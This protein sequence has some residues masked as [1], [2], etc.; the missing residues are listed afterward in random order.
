M[1][2]KTGESIQ[3]ERSV[4]PAADN[5]ISR[6]QF[7]REQLQLLNR[8]L[9]SEL[10]VSILVSGLGC[11]LFWN[12][13]PV[14][15]LLFW[16]FGIVTSIALR[17]LAIQKSGITTTE[18]GNDSWD[19]NYSIAYLMTGMLWG[20]FGIIAY[21]YGSDTHN[22]I[23]LFLLSCVALTT[24]ASAGTSPLTATVFI[25]PAFLPSTIWM[26]SSNNHVYA[27]SATA[28][29]AVAIVMIRSSRGMRDVLSRSMKLSS[30]NAD[31]IRKLV[32]EHDRTKEA[33]SNVEKINA[34]MQQEIR[35]RRRAESRI[36]ASEKQLS[37]I[38]NGMQDTIYQT[39]MDG[40]ITW[41]TPSVQQLLGLNSSEIRNRN[42]REFYSDESSYDELMHLLSMNHGH[43]H[44]HEVRMENIAGKTMWV[45]EN[46]HYKYND[47]GEI[48]GVEGTIRN[49]TA[50]KLAENELFQEKERMEVT[51]GSIGDGVIT[52]DVEGNIIY[53]NRI[54][55]H[56]TG[57]S[58]GEAFDQPLKSVFNIVDE[59]TLKTP[60]D[61]VS[62]S[63]KEGKS[64][65]LPGYLLLIHRYLNQRL[66]VEVLASPIRDSSDEII[67]VVLVFHDVSELR[68]LAQM[69]YQA[70]HDLLTGLINRRE[71]ERRVG[72]ALENA[73]QRDMEYALCYL[74]LDNFKIV[75]DTCGHA[76]GDELLMQ[77]TTKLRLELRKSDTLARL[78]GD[79]FGLLLPG[80]SQRK[81]YE[82]AENFRQI[83]ENFRFNWDKKTFRVGVS[84][85]LVM[86][87]SES[88][89]VSNILSAAD[90]A[91]YVAK[92]EGRN[93]VHMYEENDVA[94]AERHGQ[95]QWVQRIHDVLE[96]GMFQLYFQ[97][98]AKLNRDADEPYTMHGEV[99]LR[100]LDSDNTVGPGAFIPSAERYNLMP[101]IDRW[102]VENTFAALV[103]RDASE[104][105]PMDAC[106][107]NLSGQSLSDK[108]FMDFLVSEIQN[109]RVPPEILCFEITETAVIASLNNA[110]KMIALLRDM[111]CRFALDDFGVGLSSF[112][113]LKNLAVDYLKLDG[114]FIRNM[115]CDHIDHEMVRAI[116]QIGH[117]M[118]IKTIAEFVEDED[119]L[120]AVRN[121][122]VDY[123][124]GYAIARPVPIE[125]GLSSMPTEPH[126]LDAGKQ[127]VIPLLGYAAKGSK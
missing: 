97:P 9:H 66:S 13:L 6:W 16:S 55:E 85:G 79:E 27:L 88:G 23:T 12:T 103:N 83:V 92:D 25:L 114:S 90:S 56:R 46:S 3:V 109:T 29:I 77:L 93:R 8:N 49:I 73:M 14:W 28:M 1:T 96:D 42:I 115:V 94:L 116:N 26:L 124:Q 43:V 10:L 80:C 71:F 108:R 57:W 35:K 82:L 101:A 59:K 126:T 117:T 86:I 54:A 60:P 37:S 70:T 44:N 31:L 107:I 21:I 53:M 72:Q 81:A 11:A 122:G 102:V 89:S 112:S 69:T 99:L 2:D 20:C 41:T 48:V 118:N 100:M 51:L 119:I 63:L 58:L 50:Q 127:G 64:I 74:D 121:I 98:I 18:S 62:M 104:A 68:S 78:G 24:F 40:V 123:A 34:R 32:V 19:S 4:E 125:T 15:W 110:T 7:Q 113:Y 45:S 111:G 52:T 120:N 39:D 38:L 17:S 84:I 36:A 95:M 61:A 33:K 22:L 76:A 67:G 106:C 75:N 30:Y 65:M 5:S 87:G 47:R 91:C 105:P